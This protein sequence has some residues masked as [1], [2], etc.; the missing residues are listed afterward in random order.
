MSKTTVTLGSNSIVYTICSICTG[1]I[2]YNIHHSLFWAILD[3]LFAPFAWAKWL[4]CQEVNLTIIKS[5]FAFFL[6]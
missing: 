4:I 6:Q 2:G 3:T 5:S 1:I